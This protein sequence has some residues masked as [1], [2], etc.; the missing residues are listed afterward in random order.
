[1]STT[2]ETEGAQLKEDAIRHGY[3]GR[4]GDA[5]VLLKNCARAVRIAA[6]QMR[7]NFG[8]PAV[9]ADE[10]A[11][12][13]S[14]L[15][16]R[17][18]G[19]HGGRIPK[20]DEVATA[21]LIQRAKG[22]IMN[23]MHRRSISFDGAGDVSIA[24]RLEPTRSAG[25]DQAGRDER[26]TGPLTITADVEAIADRLELS[27]S[28]RKALAQAMIPGTRKEWAEHFGY[29][30]GKVFHVIAHRGRAELVAIGEE[31]I[32]EALAAIEAENA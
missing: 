15:V 6:E 3:N 4:D 1:M 9:S 25:A 11:E 22:I 2:I 8:V 31:S 12:Y 18:L 10:R 29:A 14:D 5:A 27:G 7:R 24:D 23:D 13:C 20:Q 26:L 28:A 19:E 16:A 17:I 21:Y 30:S 32:R